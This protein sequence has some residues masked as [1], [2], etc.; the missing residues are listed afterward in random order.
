MVR[1]DGLDVS[2]N[3]GAWCVM[4]TT[5]SPFSSAFAISDFNHSTSV[6]G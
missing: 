2:L 5:L 1:K 3:V 4:I 6:N